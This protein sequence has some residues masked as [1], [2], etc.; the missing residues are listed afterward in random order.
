VRIGIVND[1]RLAREALRRIVLSRPSD[2]V[3][4]TAIDG[5][6]AVSLAG[7]DPPDLIL[8]DL[9]LPKL[10][11]VEAT[12]RIMS[13]HPCPILVVTSSVSQ[14]MARVYEAMGLG[15]LGAVDTPTLR[16]DGRESG[17][18]ELYAKIDTVAKLIGGGPSP[19]HRLPAPPKARREPG[20]RRPP[21]ALLGASTGGPRVIAEML[22]DWPGSCEACVVV[23]QH[24]DESFADGLARWLAEH[25]PL[26]VERVR[27]GQGP[28]P[29]KVLVAA[30]DRHVA[31]GPDG[32]FSH[33][34]EP[35]E[36]CYHPSVDVLFRSIAEHW[37]APGAA[38]LLTGMGRDGAEG[39]KV[40]RARGWRTYAQAER[41]CPVWGMP[42]AAVEIGA[43]A[44]VL[45]PADIARAM[46]VHLSPSASPAPPRYR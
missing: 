35:R 21:L 12:R 14:H 33:T 44:E 22:E 7:S 38:A 18:A 16:A 24:M 9:M 6:E 40:L 29:R 30:C 39:L 4:W 46:A 3:A 15:A 2:E 45:G 43:A 26:A 19:A 42:K 41:G 27:D 31:M 32:R 23:V 17:A 37:P 11:G 36:S 8:M 1:L 5:E 20:S 13:E 25:C 28:E 10:D 34:D